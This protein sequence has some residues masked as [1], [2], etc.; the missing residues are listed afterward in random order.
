MKIIK[1]VIATV[2]FLG[3]FFYAFTSGGTL[4]VPTTQYRFVTDPR[5]SD[6]AD[7]APMELSIIKTGSA[8]TLEAMTFSGGGRVTPRHLS[9][10][11]VIFKHPRGNILLDT[12]LGANVDQQFAEGMPLWLKPLMKYEK[13]QP[14]RQQLQ[15][16]GIDPAKLAGV[17]ISHLHWDHAS[18]IEDFPESEIWVNQAALE[19]AQTHADS[20]PAFIADQIDSDSIR[21]TFFNFSDGPYENFEQSTDVFGDG[22]LVI[23]PMPGHTIGSV[24]VFANLQSG[25]R[26]FFTGDTTWAIEGFTHPAEKFAISK[27]LV[28]GDVDQTR[29]QIL[30]VHALMK[31]RPDLVVVPAHDYKTHKNIAAFPQFEG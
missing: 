6:P 29:E 21:W 13:T 9:H 17:I 12:G 10:A 23:V 15:E 25:K 19:F 20:D 30:K 2:L 22:S 24:G 16:N 5:L 14:A 26:Y 1:I 7:L 4:D 3:V 28:D 27:G 31:T 18:G 11:A 8:T